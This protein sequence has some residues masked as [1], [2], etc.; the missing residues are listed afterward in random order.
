MD[1]RWAFPI[2]LTMQRQ[3][4]SAPKPRTVKSPPVAPRAVPDQGKSQGETADTAQSD[5]DAM[6]YEIGFDY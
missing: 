3:A 5:A 2:P 1:D 6:N 4:G